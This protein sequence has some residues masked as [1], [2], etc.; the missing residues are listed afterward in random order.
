MLLSIQDISK[1]YGDNQ[2]LNGVTLA[3]HREQKLGLVGANGVGKS[4]LLSIIVGQLEPDTGTVEFGPGVEI[5][6]LP[7]LLTSTEGQTVA[8]LMDRALGG[9][10]LLEAQMRRLETQMA[11]GADDLDAVLAEYGR[12][13][14]HFE[15]RGGYELEY[16]TDQVMAGLRIE[17]IE[18]GRPVATLSGG[19][20]TR[21]GLAALLLS[22]PDLLLLDEPTNHL[23][24]ATL[25]WLESYLQSY[26]GGLLAV[27]H[28][29]QFLNRTVDTIV[30]IVEHSREAKQYSGNYD[31]YARVK[32]EERVKWVESYWQQQEEIWELRKA[33]RTKARQVAHNRPPR[34]GDKFLAAFKDGRVN[35]TIA[36]NV[37][38]AEERL[39]RITEEPIPKPPQELS[40][41]PDFDPQALTNATPLV[42]SNLR[43]AYGDNLVLDGV[44]CDV[45][46]NSRIVIVGANGSGKSTLLQI[47]AGAPPDE[48]EVTVAAGTVIGHLDQEQETLLQEGTLFDAY[49]NGR[50]GD[51]EEFK[52]ELLRYGLFVY[53]DLGKPVAALSIG[54]KRKLQ[55]AQLIAQNANLLLL[56]EPTNHISLDVLE[57]FETALLNFPGPVVAVSHD[58]RFIERFTGATESE[59]GALAPELWHV[60]EGR[61]HRVPGGWQ[62][63]V[64]A[65]PAWA[66]RIEA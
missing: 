8:Q 4:T 27:S 5:G 61:L 9:I 28:D 37:R 11:N 54:Q 16:R 12:L 32:A 2:V 53:E 39:R 33:I 21:V 45:H 46:A 56:D 1:A 36:R 3:L 55:I 43:K 18:R 22:A 63:Y 49:R 51:P 60:R 44:S 23:D 10:K 7:Q 48:G 34:D 59:H 19:E 38:N 62:E 41:N 20:K 13:S 64:G 57:E 50:I 66:G 40:I 65:E 29:R 26:S 6:Y 47:L 15:R 17:Y 25:E 42:A 52:A 24:F 58:R 30:E 14:E 35:D 31:F